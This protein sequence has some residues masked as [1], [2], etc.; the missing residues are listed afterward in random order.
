MNDDER[1]ENEELIH[2]AIQ[3]GLKQKDKLTYSDVHTSEFHKGLMFN[4][5]KR[6][7]TFK[8]TQI[9]KDQAELDDEVSNENTI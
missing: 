2:A 8:L 4:A 3:E 1:Q 9:A 6:T 5:F 7:T